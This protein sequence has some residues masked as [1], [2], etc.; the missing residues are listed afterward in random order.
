VSSCPF[1]LPA[2]HLGL[3]GGPILVA[4]ALT[5]S[6]LLTPRSEDGPSRGAKWL[7]GLGTLAHLI[8]LGALGVFMLPHAWTPHALLPGEPLRLD[9]ALLGAAAAALTSVLWCLFGRSE[10][11]R[12][13]EETVWTTIQQIQDGA[14]VW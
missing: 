9:M 7:L 13:A 4:V 14:S 11:K 12:N 3:V 8:E 6:L 2:V 1:W 10:F 5:I